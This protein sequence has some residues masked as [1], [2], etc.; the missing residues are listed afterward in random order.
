MWRFRWRSRRLVRSCRIRGPGDVTDASRAIG[1]VWVLR[2]PSVGTHEKSLQATAYQ[3]REELI[4][5]EGERKRN[6]LICPLCVIALFV[7]STKRID[8]INSTFVWIYGSRNLLK[9]TPHLLIYS[10]ALF[11][12]SWILGARHKLLCHSPLFTP[13]PLVALKVRSSSRVC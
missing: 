1:W 13:P 3:S 9:H 12:W 5:K 7:G 6:K 2:E 8:E 4:E 10:G 11:N